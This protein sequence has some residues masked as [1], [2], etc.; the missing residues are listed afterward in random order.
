MQ[1]PSFDIFFDLHMQKIVEEIYEQMVEPT[2]ESMI[3]DAMTLVWRHYN[4]P[5]YS[6]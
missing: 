4:R 5:S 3:W 6:W 2:V 1:D